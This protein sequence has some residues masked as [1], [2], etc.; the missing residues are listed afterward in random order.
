MVEINNKNILEV[1]AKVIETAETLKVVLKDLDFYLNAVQN[2]GT[3]KNLKPVEW[4]EEDEKYM[5]AL[6][7]KLETLN[8]YNDSFSIG[9]Y[10]VDIIANWL[11][12]LRPQSHWKP[13]EEQ[14]ETLELVMSDYEN[15][16]TYDI[17]K[18][19]LEQLKE[20]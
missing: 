10:R 3:Y 7:D 19:L 14:M 17:L 20:L 9:G 6:I 11:K 4:S 12:S 2:D 15:G 1:M 5:N 18:G 13:S 8:F 16:N